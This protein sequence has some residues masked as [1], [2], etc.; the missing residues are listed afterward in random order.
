MNFYLVGGMLGH[1]WTMMSVCQNQRIELHGGPHI[2]FAIGITY[3]ILFYLFII[4]NSIGVVPR[5]LS[6]CYIYLD[7]VKVVRD[8]N[9]HHYATL[10]CACPHGY[11]LSFLSPSYSS[12]ISF[13]STEPSPSRKQMDRWTGIAFSA[14]CS[15][16]KAL[17]EMCFRLGTRVNTTEWCGPL[18][19]AVHARMQHHRYLP[20]H[21][22]VSA[23]Y[24]I[25]IANTPTF[26]QVRIHWIGLRRV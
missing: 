10:A 3:C 14:A 16:R 12:R 25:V 22:P 5:A 15:E 21:P 13:L 24:G 11:Q 7:G 8:S 19:Y 17:D 6:Y 2:V 4:V 23:L 1:H 20:N 18:I 26:W 9:D